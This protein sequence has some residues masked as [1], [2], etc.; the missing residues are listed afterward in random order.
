[1]KNPLSAN[2]TGLPAVIRRSWQRLQ[3]PGRHWF[4]LLYLLGLVG[5]TLLA[6]L[7]KNGLKLL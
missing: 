1:M 4:F 2:Q 7:L 6:M 3:Q 5:V